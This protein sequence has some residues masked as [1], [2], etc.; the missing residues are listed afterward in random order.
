MSDCPNVEMREALPELMHGRLN[1]AEAARVR[2][3]VALCAECTAEL[4]LLGRVRRVY[5]SAPA[6][7]TAAIVR[8]L[9][10]PRLRRSFSSGVL[11]LAA[12]VVLVL[13][14]ALVMRVVSAPDAATDSVSLPVAVDSS[15]FA[16]D[17]QK[18]GRPSRVLA[19]SLGE[20]DDLDM[21][22]LQSL[23]GALE[24]IEAAP[25]AEPDTLIGSVGSIGS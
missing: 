16:P 13:G 4:E 25:S 10:Q 5:E 8:A 1:A 17:S 3:H 18:S 11:R 24:Q 7:D 22:E 2:E 21:D 9:P 19:M 14:G 15:G 23:L 6:V 12:A 20:L